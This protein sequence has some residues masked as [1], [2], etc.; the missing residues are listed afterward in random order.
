MYVRAHTHTHTPAWNGCWCGRCGPIHAA[1]LGFQ[2]LLAVL[3]PKMVAT[4]RAGSGKRAKA[5]VKLHG[6]H[7]VD[8]LVVTMAL[9]SEVPVCVVCVGVCR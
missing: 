2:A 1:C 8:V 4:I 9:E 5:R 3:I 7:G 6:V